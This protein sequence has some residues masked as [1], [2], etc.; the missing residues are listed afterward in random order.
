MSKLHSAESPSAAEVKNALGKATDYLTSIS[1]EGGYLWR[2]S[3][4]LS[5]RW[6]EEHATAS[7][8]WVQPPGTPAVGAAFLRAY[9]ATGDPAHLKAAEAAALALVRGQLQSGGW[10]Y[11]V[12]FDPARRRRWAYRVDRESSGHEG[13]AVT[14]RNIT[15]F[16]D[17]N[18]QSALHFLMA[19]AETSAAT[20]DFAASARIRDALDY[21]LAKMIEAQYPNGAWPQRWNGRP[22]DPAEYPV[23]P[24]SIPTNWPHVWPHTNYSAFYTLN[25][26]AQ[27]DCIETMLAAYLRLGDEKYLKAA[28]KGGGFLILA[29]L[30]EPQAGWAPAW[31]SA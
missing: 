14:R 20:N 6:G 24:A 5:E 9:E 25:D 28:E 30:P 11:L 4:D 23:E 8:I 31:S 10:D 21:G 29:R 13:G 26:R 1:T 19:F 17:N 15:T 22:H 7:Q 16:D 27:L 18:T 3:G 12:E 2:Y